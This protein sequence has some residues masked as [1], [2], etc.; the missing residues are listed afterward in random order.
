MKTINRHFIVVVFIV[1]NNILF[2]HISSLSSGLVFRISAPK[3]VVLTDSLLK[4][5][6]P[7]TGLTQ[8]TE[9]GNFTD[10][11]LALKELNSVKKNGLIEAEIIAYFNHSRIS[12][13]DAFSLMNNRNAMEEE[14]TAELSPEA[15][16]SIIASLRKDDFYFSLEFSLPEGKTVEDIYASVRGIQVYFNSGGKNRY[17]FGKFYSSDDA[18][19]VEQLFIREGIS[20]ILIISFDAGNGRIPLE[21]AI[22]MEKQAIGDKLKELAQR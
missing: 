7:V 20:E 3:T 5:Y 16:D 11:M 4:Q 6:A 13:E 10:Y 22:E 2:A 12:M 14:Y 8:T 15:T 18:R 17:I 1:T 9:A 19:Q 21:R